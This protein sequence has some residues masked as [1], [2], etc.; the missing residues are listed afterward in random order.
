MGEFTGNYSLP[1]SS[2]RVV[3]VYPRPP[4]PIGVNVTDDWTMEFKSIRIEAKAGERMLVTDDAEIRRMCNR[5]YKIPAAASMVGWL[6][7]SLIHR[8]FNHG[9]KSEEDAPKPICMNST[10]GDSPVFSSDSP[11]K[12][13]SPKQQPHTL[14]S[15]F[16][17][18]G[19]PCYR[20][21]KEMSCVTL[22]ENAYYT[23]V[24]PNNPL[25]DSFIIDLDQ[26]PI[27][28]HII[29][30][31]T[32]K[33]HGGSAEGYPYIRQIMARV[34]KLLKEAHRKDTVKVDY[35]LVCPKDGS[36]HKWKMPVGW[37]E[38][39]NSNDHRGEAFCI[40]V[41]AFGN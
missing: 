20:F 33:E 9:W 26:N 3:A 30:I 36:E 1:E 24:N 38:G 22:D 6:F 37:N 2:N 35:F 23:P 11:S 14:A 41:P 28:I 32:S 17:R 8:M 4:P 25:F 21:T 40:Y 39:F 31:T 13:S 16:T 27:M 12:S 34:S 29:Q 5:F 15:P 7:E 10:G 19:M 18:S